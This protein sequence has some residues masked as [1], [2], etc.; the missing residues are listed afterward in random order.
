MPPSLPPNVIDWHVA[1]ETSMYNPAPF[2]T[3]TLSLVPMPAVLHPIFEEM[4]FRPA[5]TSARLTRVI[6]MRTEAKR[7]EREFMGFL[8]RKRGEKEGE[9]Y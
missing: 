9:K 6:R 3:T 5:R 7:N 4:V 8:L 1:L 2:S